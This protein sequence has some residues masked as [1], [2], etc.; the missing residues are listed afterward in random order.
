MNKISVKDDSSLFAAIRRDKKRRRELGLPDGPDQLS[1][2]A[3][4]KARLQEIRR[5]KAVNSYYIVIE[6][7]NGI[8]RAYALTI[9]HVEV[10]AET[11]QMAKE[12]VTEALRVHLA[13]LL[14]QG[15]PLPVEHRLVETVTISLA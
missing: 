12:K 2:L 15:K 8:Y 9:P 13:E 11:P 7:I 1:D 5:E 3:T 10:Q 6:P 14:A 4:L